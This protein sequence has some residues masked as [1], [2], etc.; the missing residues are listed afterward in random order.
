MSKALYT[1]M[2]IVDAKVLDYVMENQHLLP[3]QLRINTNH[4]SHIISVGQ[5]IMR[6]KWDIGYPGGSFARAVVDNNL[7]N[8]YAFAD[9]IIREAIYL[10]VVMIKNMDMPIEIWNYKKNSNKSVATEEKL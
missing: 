6:T 7:G 5:S 3:N 8:T 4:M 2:G 1:A 9:E 10:Y